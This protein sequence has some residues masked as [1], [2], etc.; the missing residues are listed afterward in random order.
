[1]YKPPEYERDQD[2]PNQ[3]RKRKTKKKSPKLAKRNVS[4]GDN[5][6]DEYVRKEREDHEEEEDLN[7]KADNEALIRTCENL[8]INPNGEPLNS[9]LHQALVLS[10]VDFR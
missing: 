8:S 1:M 3:D 5:K 6:S 10:S 4:L 2:A 7:R 9:P